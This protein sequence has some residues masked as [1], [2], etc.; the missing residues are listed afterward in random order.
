MF[1]GPKEQVRVAYSFG[2]RV[3]LTHVQDDKP[4]CQPL[5]LA[6]AG[7]IAVLVK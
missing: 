1:R 3:F 5:A 6:L 2:G 4:A 7:S